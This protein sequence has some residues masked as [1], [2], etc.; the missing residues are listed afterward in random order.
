MIHSLFGIVALFG[1]AG[2]VVAQDLGGALDL[3][4]LGADM[5]VNNA[6][7]ANVGRGR[8]ARSLPVRRPQAAAVRLTFTPSQA[9]RRKNLAQFVVKSRKRD[10]EGAARLE[11]LF[12]SRD[13]IGQINREMGA[14]GFQAN[15]V[16]DAYAA[17]WIN[18]WLA[19]RGRTED[20]TRQQISAVRA[21]AAHAMTTLP[22]MASASDAVKQE[23]T[24]AYL[25]QT[26]LIGSV[27]EQSRGNPGQLRQLAAAVRKGAR[28]SGLNLDVMELTDD[29]FV[30]GGVG[31]N[32][33]PDRQV[34]ATADT[35]QPAGEVAP[36]V[37]AAR[38]QKDDNVILYAV[39]A[40]AAAGLAGGAWLG[41]TR[42]AGPEHRG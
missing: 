17:W 33:D 5:G 21:Q 39:A 4:Q 30:S 37:A 42:K 11:K 35:A 36:Q 1:F 15:N 10:P 12:A 34:A 27:M 2:P 18:A 25:V 3:G 19:S 28:A 32:E 9:E 22:Q 7:R 31:A 16:A 40:A 14:Y 24:E 6:I 20:A 29:G 41:R 23:M 13:I 26:A 38:E 8:T